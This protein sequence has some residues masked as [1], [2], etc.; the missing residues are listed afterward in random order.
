MS[1]HNDP[2]HNEHHGSLYEDGG[3]EYHKQQQ[4]QHLAGQRHTG[5]LYLEL[6]NNNPKT[7][8]LKEPF[9]SLLS[10]PDT[11]AFPL[12]TPEVATLLSSAGQTTT[13]STPTRFLR[14]AITDEQEMYAQG[15]IDELDRLNYHHPALACQVI[16]AGMEPPVVHHTTVHHTT[17]YNS[18]GPNHSLESTAPTYVTATMD[19]I[20]ISQ[21]QPTVAYPESSTTSRHGQSFQIHSPYT[22]ATNLYNSNPVETQGGYSGFGMLE[23]PTSDS[24]GPGTVVTNSELLRE[25][26]SVVPAD[27]KTQ[28]TMKVERKKARN[29]IAASKCRVRRL[30]RESELSQKVQLL[31]DHNSELNSEVNTL[32]SEINRLKKALIQHMNK[33]C[34]VNF[35][36]GYR[37]QLD[38]ASE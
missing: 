21:S 14:A 23:P 25:L 31:R 19:Y 16:K 9:G 20:P 18:I 24:P 37:T 4:Q 30:K 10:T 7:S 17:Q 27:L 29:R 3:A 8:A 12:S 5:G 1:I 15:F 35:P 28:E 13:T 38:S 22:S 36:E 6:S 34:Q 33:G 26:Q 32:K 2:M 11:R